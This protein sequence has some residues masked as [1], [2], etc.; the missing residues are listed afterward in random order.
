MTFYRLSLSCFVLEISGGGRS[1]GPPPPV[2]SKLARTPVGARVNRRSILRSVYG[3]NVKK[4]I[5]CVFFVALQ[6]CL[7]PG[8]A[9]ELSN[10]VEIGKM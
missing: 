9:P 1:S 6:L 4:T 8:Y 5:E 10:N 7:Y 3:K 2:G